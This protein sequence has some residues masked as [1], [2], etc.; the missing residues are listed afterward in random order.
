MSAL[1]GSGG[2]GARIVSLTTKNSTATDSTIVIDK[3]SGLINGDTLVAIIGG[4]STWTSPAGWTETLDANG[5]SYSRRVVD[6]SE[7]ATITFTHGGSPNYLAGVIIAIRGGSFDVVGSIGSGGSPAVAPSI[8]LTGA[9]LVLAAYIAN[10]GTFTT[11]SGFSSVATAQGVNSGSLEMSIAVFSKS[12]PT[13]AT[14]TVSS[15]N[16]DVAGRGAL[17]GVKTA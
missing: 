5:L 10:R 9:G 14:G 7:G 1:A 16:S 4:Q 6:G 17:I 12:F 3:P 15:T 2:S 8:T 11:P 13:G